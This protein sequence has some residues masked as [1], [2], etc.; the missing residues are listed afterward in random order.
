MKIHEDV[1]LSKLSYMKIGGTGQFLVE[2]EKDSE[3]KELDY[4]IKE[5]NRLNSKSP[6]TDFPVIF[7]GEGSN[8]IF[9]DEYHK[10][11][12]IKFKQYDI[13]KT[14]ENDDVV[15]VK[16]SAGLNWDNLVEWS[17]SNNFSGIECLSSIPG[18]VGASPIQN[19]GAY[20]QEVKN[21]II[22]VEVYE[23][24]TAKFY[25]VSNPECNFSYRNSIFK[26][27]IG[28]F[29]IVNVSFRFSKKPPKSPT[30]KDLSL[31]FLT[32]QIKNP[33]LREIRKAVIEIREQK[34]PNWKTEPNCG[35]FFQ[36]PI[37]INDQAEELIKKYPK[38][39][40]YNAGEGKTKI[41]GGWL[42]E[43]AG[44]KGKEFDGIQ[45]HEKSALV[46][47][48]TGKGNFKSLEKAIEKITKVVI[49]KFGIELKVEP[50]LI[51]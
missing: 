32:K 22:N 43:E 37:I 48:N 24:E 8:T 34:L 14:Y 33:T 38:I 41:S 31:Y 17:V 45:I 39:Q 51:K 10:K 40:Q 44:L 16:V 25:E 4:F 47:I 15:N 19:I 42:I 30:Y 11:I 20:G 23:F 6:L 36:N 13:V 2:I 18:T 5:K 21:S 3:L 26:E 35:S 9:S 46:L 1:D 27:N 49:E 29:A 28:K 12:F 7:L 50:N